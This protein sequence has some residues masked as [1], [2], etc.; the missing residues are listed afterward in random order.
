MNIAP[1]W[2]DRGRY[3]ARKRVIDILGSL[4]GLAVAL[5]IGLIVA[6]AVRLN[7]PG[8][9]FFSQRRLG[10]GEQPIT[11]Y[12]FRK[13]Y[14]GPQLHDGPAVTVAGDNRMTAVGRILERSKL[15]ELPQLWNVLRGDL[16]LV[17]PR[18]ETYEFARCFQGP[19]RQ[20]LDYKPGVFGPNQVLFRNEGRLYPKDVDPEAF[21]MQVL[22][23]RKA[24]VDLTYFPTATVREDLKWMLRGVCAAAFSSWADERQ[25]IWMATMERRMFRLASF[26]A[27]ENRN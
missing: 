27:T 22:F 25:A 20:V 13:F 17:G 18:P 23:P 7:S 2:L 8:P 24:R 19:Y 15:D 4:V 6:A 10:Q 26:P 11:I 9:I 3:L 5:P 14:H 16:S 21:Y 12:K 1:V